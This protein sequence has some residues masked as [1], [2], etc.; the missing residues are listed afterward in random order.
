MTDEPTSEEETPETDAEPAA[1][2]RPTQT[3]PSSGNRLNDQDITLGFIL[4]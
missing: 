2:E 3:P 4:K 1:E